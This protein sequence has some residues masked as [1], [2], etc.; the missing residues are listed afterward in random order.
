MYILI[1]VELP[2]YCVQGAVAIETGA[3]LVI[4]FEKIL[5][6]EYQREC[7]IIIP[8]KH[9]KVYLV[10]MPPKNRDTKKTPAKSKNA[11]T[12]HR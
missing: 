10:E 5:L 8:A 3:H 6:L 7:R 2:Q 12:T 11:G 1:C 9:Y 4:L